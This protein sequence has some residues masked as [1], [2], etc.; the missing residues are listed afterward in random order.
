MTT[1]ARSS[2][3]EHLATGI[4]N[5]AA[6][7]RP[8]GR[9]LAVRLRDLVPADAQFGEGRRQP[10]NERVLAAR[11]VNLGREER[12]GE[13]R[14]DHVGHGLDIGAG[15][16]ELRVVARPRE[17]RRQE[18]VVDAGLDELLHVAEGELDRQAGLGREPAQ[19]RL[20]GRLGTRLRGDDLVAQ[21]RE[22]RGPERKLVKRA[23][24]R[25]GCRCVR[26][27]RAEAPG[28][29]ARFPANARPG[30][31]RRSTDDRRRGSSTAR[32]RRRSRPCAAR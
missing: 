13:S 27:A 10:G 21:S 4:D 3:S 9:R 7:F 14:L 24:R 8:G 6:E 19:P 23:S 12:R 25:E 18:D 2:A 16:G 11:Q 5:P 22:K 29:A 31:A 20:E 15:M 32:R 1:I 30:R 26:G 17:D 28:R